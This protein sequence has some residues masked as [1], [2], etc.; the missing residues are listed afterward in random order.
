MHAYDQIRDEHARVDERRGPRTRDLGADV[1]RLRRPGRRDALASQ[2]DS[3][4]LKTDAKRAVGLRAPP[5]VESRR[6]PRLREGVC[7]AKLLSAQS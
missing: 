6:R 1:D 5:L 3:H 2:G 7:V 4:G